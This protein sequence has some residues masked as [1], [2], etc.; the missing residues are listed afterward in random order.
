VVTHCAVAVVLEAEVLE[1]ATEVVPWVTVWGVPVLE[2]A[3]AGFLLV[4]VLGAPG[5][6]L[7]FEVVLGVGLFVVVVLAPVFDDA[8]EVLCPA[9]VFDIPVLAVVE[10]VFWVVAGVVGVCGESV[11]ARRIA[12]EKKLQTKMMIKRFMV[13]PFE[14]V[15]EGKVSR[16]RRQFKN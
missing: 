7:V 1:P 13:H 2:A 12:V 9:E 11:C 3:T 14:N 5:L 10:D 16:P 4:A 6:E 15:V 8:E